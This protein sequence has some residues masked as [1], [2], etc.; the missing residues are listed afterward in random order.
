MKYL[1]LI[2]RSGLKY[3][4]MCCRELETLLHCRIATTSDLALLQES[5]HRPDEQIAAYDQLQE[6]F[7]TPLYTLMNETF[8][9]LE[10]L[11]KPFV[12]ALEASSELGAW[13]ADQIWYFTFGLD[14]DQ[15]LESKMERDF[16]AKKPQVEPLAVLDG[17]TALLRRA[18]DVVK[19]HHFE[20]PRPVSS[21]LSSKVLT[22]YTYLRQVFERPTDSKLI[23]FV[24]KRHTARV[25]D[26][27]FGRPTMSTPHMR[28]GAL[29]G[30]RKG[31]VGD[32]NVSFRQQVLTLTRFRK[33]LINCL[34]ATSIA[35]EGLD[36][37][38]CNVVI[39]FDLYST[40]IQ[41][42][43]SRGRAR[44]LNSK[45]VH[46]LEKDNLAHVELVRDV[47]AGEADMNRFCKALPADRILHG[48]DCDMD[49]L[50]SKER[51]HLVYI[52]RETGA[53]L[54]Y[55]SSLAVLAHFV[56]NIVSPVLFF[57][58]R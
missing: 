37:P 2:S 16:L 24:Q 40:L 36:I 55:G 41:Y 46:M 44:H 34:F 58:G 48:N 22:L 21:H 12:S 3:A 23:V 51:T 33:G 35:E 57:R 52:E 45:Y 42:I 29:M 47:R 38:D 11:D 53:K 27:L 32:T 13:C 28:T 39:R 15:K 17:N 31:G 30:T 25:L 7:Q 50:L 10:I 4:E 49:D 6:P 20:E 14:D 5:V 9:D 19:L 56:S 26:D 8:G 43:Q 54:T 18:R 1:P